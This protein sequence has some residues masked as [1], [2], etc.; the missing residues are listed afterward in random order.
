MYKLTDEIALVQSL[1][2]FTPI[3]D[4]PRT[5]GMITSANA[6]SDIYAMGA[7]PLT[8]LNIV[9]Y[10]QDSLPKEVVGEILAGG[11]AK[12][13]EAGVLLLG[14]H[15]IDDAELKFGMAV[16]GIVHPDKIVTNAGAAGQDVIVLTKP[17][18]TGIINTAGKAE[19]AD[20][21]HLDAASQAM[22][23]LNRTASELALR[24][25]VHAITD[26][27]GFGLAG[28]LAEMVIA[29]DVGVELD[30]SAVPV[31]EGTRKYAE[32]GL[33]PGGTHRNKEFYSCRFVGQEDF[34]PVD[35]DIICDAQTSGGLLIALPQK[36][37]QALVSELHSEGETGA[38]IARVVEEPRGKII[39][40]P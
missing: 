20:S 24:H 9:A 11:L 38:V 14:G 31:L 21:A 30:V 28:H 33:V 32:M 1:D 27:T 8:A 5:F 23:L 10:P 2:F 15:T 35:I 26:V 18:G 40:K 7:R 22:I 37:A 13:H 39:L 34:S 4:D 17:I 6:L 36:D 19:M 25:N 3:V 16:T 12:L 29:S